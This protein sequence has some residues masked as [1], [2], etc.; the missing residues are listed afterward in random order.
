MIR[1]IGFALAMTGFSAIGTSNDALGF[2]LII[3]G[4]CLLMGR[5]KSRGG[6]THSGA[7]VHAQQQYYSN[8]TGKYYS[9]LSEKK[10]AEDL[11]LANVYSD[12]RF[13]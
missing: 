7:S 12:S 13:R 2:V 10:R 6:T 3:I 1:L 9:S 8:I 11:H 5:K 4:A